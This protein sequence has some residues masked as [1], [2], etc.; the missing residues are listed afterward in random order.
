MAKE[1]FEKKWVIGE[2]KRTMEEKDDF[3]KYVY[4]LE[5][6]N[7]SEKR[8]GRM[9]L[10]L[11]IWNEEKKGD[12]EKER[13][14]ELASTYKSG[15]AKFIYYDSVGGMTTY[16]NIMD[17]KPAVEEESVEEGEENPKQTSLKKAD[18]KYHVKP[19]EDESEEK[20]DEVDW[21][22]KERR[23]FRCEAA[24]RA[25]GWMQCYLKAIEL[26][27]IKKEEFEP[28]D[29]TLDEEGLFFVADRFETFIYEGKG[30]VKKEKQEEC[31]P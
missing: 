8:T 6:E 27:L 15:R 23:K 21:D 30:G 24:T 20:S 28:K 18:N 13:K 16:H 19:L 1:G 7:G 5:V 2:F 3:M 10:S 25:L 29:L 14:T 31:N 26:G 9:K 11:T 12:E 22:G 4:Q 17:I